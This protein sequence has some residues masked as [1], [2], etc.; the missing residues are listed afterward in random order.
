[1]MGRKVAAEMVEAAEE[2]DVEELAGKIESQEHRRFVTM[3]GPA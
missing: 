2:E 3:Q 1:M